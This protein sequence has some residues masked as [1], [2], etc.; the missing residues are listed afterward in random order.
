MAVYLSAKADDPVAYRK[1]FFFRSSNVP[2][3]EKRRAYFVP[4]LSIR[5]AAS[6]T[7]SSCRAAL[8][9]SS[10][11]EGDVS[12]AGAEKILGSRQETGA[13][14]AV[15]RSIDDVQRFGL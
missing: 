1:H 6:A 4:F 3:F 9:S 12:V 8:T 14:Y 2:V 10:E 7:S 11:A 13:L 5:R 15:V